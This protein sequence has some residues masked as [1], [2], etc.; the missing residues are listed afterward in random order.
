MA[1]YAVDGGEAADIT[2]A[3][4]YTFKRCMSCGQMATHSVTETLGHHQLLV[5]V[6]CTFHMNTYI[7]WLGARRS[8][9][10]ERIDAQTRTGIQ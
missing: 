9:V 3:P 1:V 5:T 7:D 8:A 6:H 2:F 4:G 10:I